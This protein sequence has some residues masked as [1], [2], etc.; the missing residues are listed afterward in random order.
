M[1]RVDAT[2]NGGVSRFRDI[3][4]CAA[5]K[6]VAISPHMFPHIHSRLVAACSYEA[7]IEWGVPGMGVHPMDDC[8][9]QPVITDGRMAPLPDGLGFGRLVDSCWIAKQSVRD[10]EGLLEDL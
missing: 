9:D 1:L 10:P 3:I 7:P 2:T 8:L 6:S 4:R 5:R